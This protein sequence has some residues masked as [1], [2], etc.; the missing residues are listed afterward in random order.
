MVPVEATDTV[1]EIVETVEPDLP[2]LSTTEGQ[3]EFMEASDSCALYNSGIL[4]EMARDVPDYC[5]QILESEGKRFIIVDKGKM[6]LFLYDPY[7]NII[8]S[9]GIACAKNY[10]TRR[11][12]WDSKTTEGIFRVKRVEDSTDWYFTDEDGTVGTTKGVYGPRFIR[13]NTPAIGIHG[14]GTPSSIGKRISHGCI[15]VTNDNILDLVKYVEEGMPV[16][17][18]PGPRDMAANMQVGVKIPSVVSEPGTPRAKPSFVSEEKK[19]EEAAIENAEGEDTTDV[20]STEGE[21]TVKTE[22]VSEPS[23][24]SSNHSNSAETPENS[25]ESTVE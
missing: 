20:T 4:P 2:D 21:S 10:G 13:L 8:K 19:T 15:R 17:I 23:A 11:K 5:R 7:G 1:A 9:C 12:Q 16:I 24:E 14:T 3:L 22:S 25:S 18:S 6:K